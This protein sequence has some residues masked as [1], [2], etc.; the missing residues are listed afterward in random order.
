LA[1]TFTVSIRTKI[2]LYNFELYTDS[3]FTRFLR[4]SVLMTNRQSHKR[5]RLVPELMTSDDLELLY[6]F[7]FSPN[8]AL[9]RIF[10]RQQWLNERR[11]DP[12]YQRQKCSTMSPVSGNMRHLRI[13]TGFP[14][15]GRQM[16]VGLSKTAIFA[17]F[18]NLGGY[19]FRNVK[20]KTSNITCDMLCCPLSACNW[21]Q[22]E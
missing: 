20:D 19:F 17:I 9:A 7:K 8:F 13:F 2:D 15:V 14:W 21:L 1:G 6:K 4:R 11:Q 12:H 10:G 16:T 18:G 22:N 3:K 5:F